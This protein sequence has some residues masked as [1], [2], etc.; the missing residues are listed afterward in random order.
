MVDELGPIETS[1][2]LPPSATG[3]HDKTYYRCMIFVNGEWEIGM[4]N[5]HYLCWDDDEGDDFRYDP[6]VPTH[7][8][9]LPS[10]PVQP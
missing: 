2:Q 1:V 9:P 3:P 6:L 7:W 4:W 8:M 10:P 5:R